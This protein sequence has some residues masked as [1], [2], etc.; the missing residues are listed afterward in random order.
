MR[1]A[2]KSGPSGTGAPARVSGSS[3]PAAP[4][5]AGPAAVPDALNV[6][7]TAQFVAVVQLEVSKLPDV[8]TEKVEKLRAQMDADAYHPDE[9]AVAW[10]LV[11]EHTPSS[12]E[13]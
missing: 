1:V 11:K 12:Q 13:G 8:R 10:G 3:A 7:N 9:E 6:S 5:S 2:S 4:V